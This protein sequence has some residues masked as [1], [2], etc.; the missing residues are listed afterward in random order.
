MKTLY[1]VRHAKAIPYDSEIPDKARAITEEGR[2]YAIKL[3]K[4]LKSQSVNIEGM[5]CSDALR[6]R[7]TAEILAEGLGFPKQNIEINDKLYTEGVGN[8]LAVIQSL[9][10]Q[11][12][13]AM[14]I[15]HNPT[16]SLLASYLCGNQQINLSTCGLFA[17][18][19]EV[20]EWKLI[21]EVRG[22]ELNLCQ[23]F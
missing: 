14:I 22:R 6:A 13:S 5:F 7:Q 1:L 23:P 20:G 11:I 4:Q 9:P 17:M 19:F 2:L 18:E 8:T 3:A 16:L 12:N 15:A 21:T 10:D